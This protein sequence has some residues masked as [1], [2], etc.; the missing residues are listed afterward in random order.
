MKVSGILLSLAL[1]GS[2][3][4]YGS[5]PTTADGTVWNYAAARGLA[6]ISPNPFDVWALEAQDQAQADAQAQQQTKEG[7]GQGALKGSP[8]HI[9]FIIPAY[10]VEYLKNVKPLSAHEKLQEW[11]DGAY[12]P[13]GLAAGATEALLEHSK[14]DGFCGYGSGM[15]AYG[16]CYGSALMDSTWSSFLGDYLFTTWLHQDPRY[17]RLGEG[18]VGT[19]VW[20]SFTRMFITRTDQGTW[21]FASASLLG[22]AIAA[23]TSNLYYPKQDRGLGLTMSR[24]GWDLGGTVIFNLEAE[25]WP[26]VKPWIMRIF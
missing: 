15:E 12:D 18:S 21:A 14:V 9:F 19:R 25:Y 10:N 11:E 20:Y 13:I 24:V 1:A 8:K 2:A 22:T 16:K 3:L 7:S 4:A 17:F 26:D 23:A 6:S 5:A